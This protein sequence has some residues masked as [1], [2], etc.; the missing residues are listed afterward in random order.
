MKM[1]K[2]KK[3]NKDNSKLKPAV[4][5]ESAMDWKFNLLADDNV[6]N[7]RLDATNRDARPD[8]SR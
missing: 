8:T 2:H 6:N 7:S 1:T 5:D 4:Q 3:D